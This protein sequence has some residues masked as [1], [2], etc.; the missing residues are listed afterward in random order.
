MIFIYRF[1]NLNINIVI[2]SI[3]IK[4]LSIYRAI[5]LSP[6]IGY[7]DPCS[8]YWPTFGYGQYCHTA[9]TSLNRDERLMF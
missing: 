4:Y 3:E 5:N 7:R 8:R 6:F 9:K 1:L 2:A